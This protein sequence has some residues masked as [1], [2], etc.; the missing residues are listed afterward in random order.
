MLQPSVR[1]SAT[2]DRPQPWSGSSC[3]K[4]SF[5]EYALKATTWPPYV[6]DRV[7]ASCADPSRERGGKI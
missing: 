6:V 5:G 1:S 4:V 3:S 2:N 7:R